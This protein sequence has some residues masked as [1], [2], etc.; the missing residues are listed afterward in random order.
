MA[1]GGLPRLVPGFTHN[2][3]LQLY[4]K[5]KLWNIQMLVEWVGEDPWRQKRRDSWG[6]KV[7]QAVQNVLSCLIPDDFNLGGKKEKVFG[8]E[9][10]L[11]LASG[12]HVI[13]G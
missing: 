5:F 13:T 12:L 6:R 3:Q 4:L 8:V 2:G 11:F 1:N 7:E 9:K 10:E